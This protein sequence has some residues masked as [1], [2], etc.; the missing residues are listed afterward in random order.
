MKLRIY[1]QNIWGNMAPTE[2]IGNRNGLI[3]DLIFAQDADICCFQECNPET[4]RAGEA[5]IARLLAPRYAEVPT[6]AGDRNFTPIF[7]RREKLTVVESGW[8]RYRGFNDIDSKSLTWCVLEDRQEK[9]AFAC[10]ST[11]FWWKH[12]GEED[13]LQRLENVEQLHDVVTQL[14]QKHSVP[15][16]FS[17]DLNCGEN[18]PQGTRPLARLAELG[19]V[20]VQTLARSRVGHHTVHA[21]PVKNEQGIYYGDA[22]PDFT[23]DHAFLWPDSRV[24][25]ETFAVDTSVKALSTSDHCPICIDVQVRGESWDQMAII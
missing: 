12:A 9:T 4:S 5:D 1:N 16:L 10:V 18:A 7:Y 23:L 20:P 8:L 11:H 13:N 3:R 14:R 24:S 22:L 25:V 17:G 19:Y 15:V 2:C 21:Y 6:P